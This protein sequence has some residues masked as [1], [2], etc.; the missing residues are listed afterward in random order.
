M[1]DGSPPVSLRAARRI[2]LAAQG[3]GRP[4]PTGKVDAGH[5]RRL[6]ERLGLLQL[7][8]VN[9]L[10]PSHYLVPFSRL[11]PYDRGRLDRLAAGRRLTE[12]WAHEASLVP[13]E[14]WPL[15]AERRRRFVARPR[16]FAAFLDRRPDYVALVLDEV[17]RRGPLGAEDLSDP[18][19][20][21]RRLDH[22]WFGTVPRAILETFL[23]RG[24][25]AVARRRGFVRLYD[26][27]ERVVPA[28]DFGRRVEA[29][30]AD[31]ELLR[32]A[33][34]AHGV[35]TAADLADYF[36]MP[37]AEARPRLAELVAAGEL[38]EVRVDGWRETAFLDPVARRPRRIRAAALLSPFDPLIWFRPRTAR[39]FGFDFRFEIFVPA[40]KRRWG[41]YV[42][43]FLLDE[44]LVARVD[45]KA[46]RRAGVLRVLGAWGEADAE[47][48]V[49]AGP[50]AAELEGLAGWLGLA[51]V[52]VAG[53][54]DLLGALRAA[55]V[56]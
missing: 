42:L 5:L 36:R 55:S 44:R 2:A 41:A 11:G 34:R 18:P 32:R 52:E 27:A 7:D 6:I 14:A 15:F 12:Q 39:L 50:L 35:G 20:E 10:L 53:R 47:P 1:I 8:F 17:R 33:A 25:L 48:A 56:R 24:V 43:P 22:D 31:R 51:G 23:G 38:V 3:F 21:S 16:D 9:V 29:A 13:V 28:E 45:L 19:G 54:G 40:A 30:E 37:V 46:D 49:V 26:L 4:R